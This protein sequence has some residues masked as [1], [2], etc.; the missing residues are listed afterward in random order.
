[1]PIVNPA[2]N[3]FIRA[4]SC[5]PVVVPFGYFLRQSASYDLSVSTV[6]LSNH[7]SLQ[8]LLSK[9]LVSAQA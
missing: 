3:F 7:V 9:F 2:V 1:M 8:D 4:L 5:R 6:S